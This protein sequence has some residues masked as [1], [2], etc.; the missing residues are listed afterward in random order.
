V[1]RSILG[2]TK[3]I[4]RTTWMIAALLPNSLTADIDRFGSNANRVL[5]IQSWALWALVLVALW[6]P[7]PIALTTSRMLSPLVALLMVARL[8]STEWSPA[9]ILAALLAAVVCVLTFTAE[10][11]SD[12]AQAGAFGNERRFLLRLPAPLLLPLILGWLL[13]AVAVIGA[14]LVV[15][16]TNWLIGVPSAVVALVVLWFAPQRL[17]QLSKRWLVRVPAGWVVHDAVLLA[18]NILVRTHELQSMAI[19]PST[20][21]AFDLTG[22]TSGTP[23]EICMRDSTMVRLTP[24]AARVNKTLDVVHTKAIL[25]APTRATAPLAK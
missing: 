12:Q 3:W 10:F 21:E 14:P 24:F 17:H 7:H 6:V 15:A 5:D 1:A 11:G 16:S 20:T 4:T 13:F 22:L 2:Y 9:A 18:D 23:L 19:A 25:V 8:G